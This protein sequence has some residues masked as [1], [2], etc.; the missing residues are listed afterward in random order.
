MSTLRKARAG[1]L[2]VACTI[3]IIT[4]QLVLAPIPAQAQAVNATLLGN[5]TDS[6]GAF[7]SGATVV[8]LE[9]GTG[10]T[11]TTTTNASGNYTFSDLPPGTYSVTGA[12]QGFKKEIR[13]SV[14]VAVNSSV[15]IDL[16]LQPG[17]VTES[18]EV[19]AVAPIL[20]TDRADV[21][22]KI[23]EQQMTQLPIG[24]ANRNFQNLVALIPGVDKPHRDH[25]EFFNPQDT[26][27]FETNG[28]SREFNQLAIEG[29]NDDERTGLLQIYVP[30]AEAIE[31]VDVTV[32]S[33]STTA[34][35]PFNRGRIFS[36]PQPA[37]VQSPARP[38]TTMAA[39][40]ADQSSRTKPSSSSIF[41]GL[42]ISVVNSRISNCRPMPSGTEMSRRPLHLERRTSTIPSRVIRTAPVACRS[43]PPTHQA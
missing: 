1:L 3:A 37:P 43:S 15:R 6:S 28:Q 5:V 14:D 19:T 12:M 23:V 9:T 25:S 4:V 11:R 30:P 32:H 29:V 38:T 7:V 22:S 35:V 24:G 36:A 41:C 10:F 16:A 31:T 27:S 8:I 20:Q 42:T 13:P 39:P 17:A 26:L 33:T 2:L 34:S 18:V 21:S 40:S